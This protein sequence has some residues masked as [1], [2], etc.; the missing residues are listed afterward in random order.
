MKNATFFL[1]LLLL[2]AMSSVDAQIALGAQTEDRSNMIT[3]EST[4]EVAEN[5]TLIQNL[6][7]IQF[8]VYPTSLDKNRIKTPDHVSG[9]WLIHLPTVKVKGMKGKGAYYVVKPYLTEQAARNE[10]AALKKDHQVNCWYNKELTGSNFIL[11]GIT[12]SA[13]STP[14]L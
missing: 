9:A 6:Y 12:Q 5:F 1:S 13:V 10:A 2:T 14:N 8:G 3:Q 4:R 7:F 11:L